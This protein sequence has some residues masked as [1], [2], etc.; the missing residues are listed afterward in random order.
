VEDV[1]KLP[2]TL[3]A[4]NIWSIEEGMPRKRP[5]LFEVRDSRKHPNRDNGWRIVGFVNG[6][7]KQFWFKSQKEAQIAA[8]DRNAEITAFGTQ[9]VLSPSDRV[10]AVNAAERLA[11]F[12]KNLDDA[13]NFYLSHLKQLESSIP[14]SELCKVVRAEFDRRLSKNEAS[15]RHKNTMYEALKKLEA[16]FGDENAKTLTGVQVKEWLDEQPWATKTRNKLL[17]YIRNAWNVGVEKGVLNAPLAVKNYKRSKKAR[18]FPQSL[19][20]GRGTTTT[21]EC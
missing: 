8:A 9:I 7:R 3:S 4:R 19:D 20:P 10:R 1:V 21:C 5:A 12:G 2:V 6:I 17:G 14:V 18:G 11:P 16:K 15:L 13:V